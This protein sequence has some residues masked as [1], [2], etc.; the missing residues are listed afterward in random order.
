MKFANTDKIDKPIFAN[1]RL[2]GK[3]TMTIDEM[4]R[5]ILS[6]RELIAAA[7]ALIS[8]QTIIRSH[9]RIN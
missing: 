9:R 7:D 1:I 8:D 2:S 3:A 4:K 6:D 5:K